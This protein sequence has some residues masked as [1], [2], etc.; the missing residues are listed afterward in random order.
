MTLKCVLTSPEYTRT[1]AIE[2]QIYVKIEKVHTLMISAIEKFTSISLIRNAIITVFFIPV[3]ESRE[4]DQALT[5]SDTK[6][7]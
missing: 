6:A 4:L 5:L 3:T 1:H 7:Q 2:P